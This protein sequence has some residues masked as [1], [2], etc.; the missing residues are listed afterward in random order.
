DRI[1]L[2][3]T[4]RIYLSNG[5]L[6]NERLHLAAIAEGGFARAK[7]VVEA[8]YEALNA[9]PRFERVAHPLLRPG[10]GARTPAAGVGEPHPPGLAGTPPGG[11][12]RARE[13]ARSAQRSAARAAD[14]SAPFFGGAARAVPGRGALPSPP[15][16]WSAPAARRRASV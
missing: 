13:R 15:S 3:E 6:P 12:C 9:E 8:L 11:R 16:P 2:F 7:G 5:E 4:A 1:A 10:H 14:G